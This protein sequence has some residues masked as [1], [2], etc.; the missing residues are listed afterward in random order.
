MRRDNALAHCSPLTLR[1]WQFWAI[2][3]ALV[4]TVIARWRD[5]LPIGNNDRWS[6][7]SLIRG[8]QVFDSSE[9]F[10]AAKKKAVLSRKPDNDLYQ[11]A[12][13]A[14]VP[15]DQDEYGLLNNQ[16]HEKMT[17][18]AREHF[19]D[20]PVSDDDPRFRGVDI[21]FRQS[22]GTAF[23]YQNLDW[24]GPTYECYIGV[25][26]EYLSATLLVA[27]QRLLVAEFEDWCIVVVLCEDSSFG[28]GDEIYLFSDQALL[29][30]D[31]A[32]VLQLPR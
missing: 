26:D 21:E 27:F 10:S 13:K 17:A 28:E 1:R 11:P 32:T 19:K 22:I 6:N 2:A 15:Y 14:P 4:L 20:T 30:Q 8:M 12:G 16:L 31:A 23:T 29:T 25:L 18:T 3:V 5:P 24:Y 7:R 9:D